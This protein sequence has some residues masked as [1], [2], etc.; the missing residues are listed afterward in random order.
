M[1]LHIRLAAEADALAIHQLSA[2]VQEALSRAGSLQQFG[3]IPLP[4]VERAARQGHV[5]VAEADGALL[6]GVF[7][8]PLSAEQ[9]AA[10]RIPQAEHW[11]LS[12]LMI[13]PERRGQGWG[14]ELVAALQRLTRG[15]TGRDR[16][17]LLGG[18]RQAAA[19][20]R[21]AGISSA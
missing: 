5:T 9:S 10:W 19:P 8:E 3:P 4:V 6:G 15:A 18:Q 16:A 2:R 13:D 17:R 14:S 20:V 1:L 7:L 11:F 12:K 21:G